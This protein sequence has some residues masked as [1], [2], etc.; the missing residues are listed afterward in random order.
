[1]KPVLIQVFAVLTV[2]ALVVGSAFAGLI[3]VPLSSFGP[4]TIVERFSDPINYANAA[5]HGSTTYSGAMVL[6]GINSPY[7]FVGTGLTYV[8]P[9]PNVE[10]DWLPRISLLNRKQSFSFG[11]K[12][13]YGE[14]GEWLPPYIPGGVDA[15]ALVQTASSSVHFD[16]FYLT[17]PGHGATMVGLYP[18]MAGGG[19]TELRNPSLDR[20]V[21]T[22]YGAD[23]AYLG[24]MDCVPQNVSQWANNFW[25][26]ADGNGA[27]ITKIGIDYSTNYG[28][29]RPGIANLM[30]IPVPEPTTLTMLTLLLA[31][32]LC[33]QV[34]SKK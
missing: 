28:A 2:L 20:I 25:G 14:L 10:G 8:S 29:S 21:I 4:G 23:N 15:R 17:F 13:G 30:F 6:I 33:W 16:P 19:I 9:V 27:P 11:T 18:I 26:F 12:T 32:V 3:P 7:T 31:V 24:R 34:L 1:M 5:D 22:A